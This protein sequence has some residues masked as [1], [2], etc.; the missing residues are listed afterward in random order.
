MCENWRLHWSYYHLI[1]CDKSSARDSR[2]NRTMSRLYLLIWSMCLCSVHGKCVLRTVH[3]DVR[4]CECYSTASK[5]TKK[6]CFSLLRI[7]WYFSDLREM[8]IIKRQNASS[9]RENKENLKWP[10]STKHKLLSNIIRE[11]Y[12]KINIMQIIPY[13]WR[14][15]S[16]HIPLLLGDFLL[17]LDFASQMICISCLIPAAKCLSMTNWRRQCYKMTTTSDHIDNVHMRTMN[18]IDRL[19]D[20]GH[21]YA[22][23]HHRVYTALWHSSSCV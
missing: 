18:S 13:V 15:L 22:V 14:V 12:W 1:R 2:S 10:T 20:V 11:I 7:L 4:I 19:P 8:K 16:A 23:T 9:L 17:F 3:S 6:N 5:S 21:L